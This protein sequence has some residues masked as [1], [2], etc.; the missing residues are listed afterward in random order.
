[1]QK[2]KSF[3][4]SKNFSKV[5]FSTMYLGFFLIFLSAICKQLINTN[6]A[7]YFAFGLAHRIYLF[8]GLTSISLFYAFIA[9][10]TNMELSPKA[11]YMF[12]VFCFSMSLLVTGLIFKWNFWPLADVLLTSSFTSLSLYYAIKAFTQQA[13]SKFESLYIKIFFLGFAVSVMSLLFRIQAWPGCEEM[14]AVGYGAMMVVV[15]LQLRSLLI[16]STW[17]VNINSP[18]GFSIENFSTLILFVLLSCIRLDSSV[19]NA[20]LK[21]KI[22][23]NITIEK[24]ISKGVNNSIQFSAVN[25]SKVKFA[26]NSKKKNLTIDFKR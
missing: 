10:P 23:D 12:R 8:L 18:F 13:H 6:S 25:Y 9:L 4:N 16:D 1:M 22:V 7:I 26:N 3:Y 11:N 2:T 20:S 19:S 15:F 24:C 21:A 5:I 14:S 17:L